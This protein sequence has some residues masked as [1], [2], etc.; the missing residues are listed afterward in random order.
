MSVH[1]ILFLGGSGAI[2]HRSAKAL[3]AAHPDVPLLIGGRD[4]AKAQQ[5]A[6]EIGGAQGVVIDPAADQ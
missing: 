3:R 4:L 5:A 1:P 6:E 2:G